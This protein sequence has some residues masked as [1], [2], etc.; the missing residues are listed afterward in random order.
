MA[1]IPVVERAVGQD[2][3]AGWHRLAGF[4]SFN[5][6]LAHIVLIT[7]GYA[8]GDLAA[9]ARDVLEPDDDLPRHAARAGRDRCAW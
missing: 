4:T 3:L 5:L 9:R 1:R 6:M 8:A 7:W 2:R